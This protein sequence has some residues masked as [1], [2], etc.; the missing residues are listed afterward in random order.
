MRGVSRA[1]ARDA[2]GTANNSNRDALKTP[3]R[4]DYGGAERSSATGPPQAEPERAEREER[5]PI[6]SAWTMPPKPR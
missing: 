3:A 4:L 6:P 1:G 2:G 5:E